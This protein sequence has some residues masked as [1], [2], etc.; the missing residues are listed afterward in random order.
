M[1]HNYEDE[2]LRKVCYVLPEGAKAVWV[3]GATHGMAYAY[4]QVYEKQDRYVDVAGWAKIECYR[5]KW[6]SSDPQL[7]ER[8]YLEAF[9]LGY[10]KALV[11]FQDGSY[12]IMHGLDL[13][14]RMWCFSDYW[15]NRYREYAASVAGPPRL[16]AR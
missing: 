7:Y 12:Q 5:H 3:D 10:H 6:G 15:A 2:G 14:L 16:F 1:Q 9:H 11:A 4:E 13:A 8:I